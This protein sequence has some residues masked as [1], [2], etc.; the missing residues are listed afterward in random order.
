MVLGSVYKRTLSVKTD[1]HFLVEQVFD[2]DGLFG[3]DTIRS[4]F[5]ASTF[6]DL[7][8]AFTFSQ[9]PAIVGQDNLISFQTLVRLSQGEIQSVNDIRMG[10]LLVQETADADIDRILNELDDIIQNEDNLSTFDYR[11]EIAP[12]QTAN[13]ILTL[14]FLVL[15]FIAMVISTLI[16]KFTTPPSLFKLSS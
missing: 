4:R 10:N 3:G 15:A 1:E 11:D 5:A 9:F 16:S 7:S 13:V 14:F 12:I 2:N 6:L 8:P